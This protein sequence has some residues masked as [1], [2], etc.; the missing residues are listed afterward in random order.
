MVAQTYTNIKDE[1]SSASDDQNAAFFIIDNCNSLADKSTELKHYLLF[2][3]TQAN[4]IDDEN[5]FI[6]Q[7]IK[8]SHLLDVDDS[9]QKSFLNELDS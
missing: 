4:D 8:F 9:Q 1:V 5:T 7:H 2:S 6:S 3:P